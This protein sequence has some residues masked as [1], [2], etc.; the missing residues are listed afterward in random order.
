MNRKIPAI[1]VAALIAAI[2]LFSLTMRSTPEGEG[3]AAVAVADRAGPGAP[4]PGKGLAALKR[5]ATSGKSLYVFLYRDE[6]EQTR[7]MR[8]VF[9]EAVAK[10]ADTVEPLAVNIADPSEAEFAE[11]LGIRTAQM[12]LVLTLGSD[13]VIRDVFSVEF[14]QQQI[15]GAGR[16]SGPA[17]G[18]G[19]GCSAGTG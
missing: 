15:L 18:G 9:D 1:A 11:K 17:S 14:T 16:G 7:K 12:P 13:G 4:L 10:V 6:N 19:C 2:A 5:L 8:K 3:T